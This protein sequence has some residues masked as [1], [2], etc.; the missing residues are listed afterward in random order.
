M[1]EYIAIQKYSEL[2]KLISTDDLEYLR[3]SQEEHS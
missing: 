1:Q 3:H 2:L